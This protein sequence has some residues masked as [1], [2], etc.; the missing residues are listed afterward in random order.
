M[1]T[2]ISIK[3]QWFSIIIGLRVHSFGNE[4]LPQVEGF[5]DLGVLFTCMG[6]WDWWIGWCSICSNVVKRFDLVKRESWV[7]KQNCQFVNL[8][9]SYSCDHKLWVV[10]KR[11]MLQIKAKEMSFFQRVPKLSLRDRV[12]QKGL[13][14]SHIQEST[15]VIS[16]PSWAPPKWGVL[17][18]S[19]WQEVPQKIQDMMEGLC[20]PSRLLP[21]Q[22]GQ[23]ASSMDG[24]KEN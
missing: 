11:I 6:M 12:T 1:R 22:P 23:A 15:E 2:N 9:F 8:L 14:V 13:R 18:M 20:H 16:F 3:M 4:L 10:T 17:G 7:R 24:K 21:Q 19:N 5:K